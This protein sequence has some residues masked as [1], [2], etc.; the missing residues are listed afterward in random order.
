MFR[1][2][3]MLLGT[4]SSGSPLARSRQDNQTSPWPGQP[5][6]P[7]DDRDWPA[8]GGAP[9]TVLAPAPGQFG[10]ERPGGHD[11]RSGEKKGRGRRRVAWIAVIAVAVLIFR[12]AIASITLLGLSAALHMAGL[13]VKLPHVGFGWPWQGGAPATRDID[14]GPWVLQKIEGISRPALGEA[15]FTF[16]F[17]HRVSK[18]V[19]PWPCWYSSTFYAVGHAAATVDLNPG[20]SWWAKGTGHYRLQVL[21]Q[22]AG[23]KPGRVGVTMVL[24][25]PQLPS[26]VHDVSIDNLP[27]RPVSTQHSWT[28]PGFGCGVLLRPQFSPAVLYADAQR[29]AFQK[30]TQ[31]PQIT[32]PLVR[33]AEA[34]A[35]QTIRNNFLQPTLNALGYALERFTLRWSGTAPG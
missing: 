6:G 19:G 1:I 20:P 17:T 21:S 24:P 7:A 33:T 22:P 14:L 32:G 18:S 34:T 30:A 2:L 23:G 4:L 3:L 31:S 26:S 9:T 29:L 8:P 25:R 16:M 5:G 27:S 15:N 35:A 10:T 13:D 28:Y 11:S 12:R